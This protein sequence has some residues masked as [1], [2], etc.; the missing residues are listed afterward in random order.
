M[1]N[2]LD[3]NFSVIGLTETKIK[4]GTCSTIPI[5][6][7]GYSYEHT[8]TESACGGALLYLSNSLHYKPRNDLL[9]YKAFFT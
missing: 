1:L 8:P 3:F 9:I 4:K 6:I 5:S 7:K 2:L